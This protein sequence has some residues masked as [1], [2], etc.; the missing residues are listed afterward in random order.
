MSSSP[1]PLL[2][3]W[4]PS[5]TDQAKKRINILEDASSGAIWLLPHTG[6]VLLRR[7]PLSWPESYD[8]A[9]HFASDHEYATEAPRTGRKE[10]SVGFCLKPGTEIRQLPVS[11]HS[12]AGQSQCSR[13]NLVASHK[14]LLYNKYTRTEFSWSFNYSIKVFLIP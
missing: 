3:N 7:R 14:L 9:A 6:L 1:H 11:W 4:G 12:Q 2:V 8:L 10:L 5:L 13:T